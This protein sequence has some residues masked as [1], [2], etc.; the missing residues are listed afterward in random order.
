GVQG[1]NSAFQLAIARTQSLHGVLLYLEFGCKC[2]ML[3][4]YFFI[5]LLRL[6]EVLDRKSVVE[7]K[8][9]AGGSGGGSGGDSTRRATSVA[10]RPSPCSFFFFQQKP[11]SEIET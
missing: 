2:I 4:A 1:L 10:T 6:L 9:A 8:S 7:G 5:H 3:L 11:A